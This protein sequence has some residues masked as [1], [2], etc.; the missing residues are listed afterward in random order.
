MLPCGFGNVIRVL[1]IVQMSCQNPL[2][3]RE[4]QSTYASS[5]TSSTVAEHSTLYAM[6]SELLKSS[7]I[8]CTES[9]GI[10][11]CRVLTLRHMLMAFAVLRSSEGEQTQPGS[12]AL[13]SLE[14]IHQ[15]I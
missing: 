5:A 13:L 8:A 1:C 7:Q 15:I 11:F 10:S 6:L 4:L 2:G 9:Q 12:S 3:S 14:G